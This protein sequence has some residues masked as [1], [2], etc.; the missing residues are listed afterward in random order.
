MPTAAPPRRARDPVDL[1]SPTTPQLL[2]AR[3]NADETRATLFLMDDRFQTVRELFE[4]EV[5][6]W[7]PGQAR[8]RAS[9]RLGD[10]SQRRAAARW[11]CEPL[12]NADVR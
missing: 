5:H 2:C 3:I 9:G 1:V 8:V 10:R 4:L 12:M 11:G 7:R 6:G